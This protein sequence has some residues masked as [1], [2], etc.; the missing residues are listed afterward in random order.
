MLHRSNAE[1]SFMEIERKSSGGSGVVLEGRAG[2]VG[3]RGLRQGRY[4]GLA[5]GRQAGA[6]LP[7]SLRQVV[8]Q[9]ARLA[10]LWPVLRVIRRRRS[11]QPICP[12]S[13]PAIILSAFPCGCQSWRTDP[14]WPVTV[15]TLLRKW[16]WSVTAS[17]TPMLNFLA[18]MVRALRAV[19]LMANSALA[20]CSRASE[21]G[22]LALRLPL[23]PWQPPE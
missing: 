14:G 1:C 7:G 22:G 8:D 23:A 13:R 17:R 19:D 6:D 16:S 18:M 21:A 12:F 15:G 5:A 4:S 20:V 10:T 9:R 2:G 11:P 3:V